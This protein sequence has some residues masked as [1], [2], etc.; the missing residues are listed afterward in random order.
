VS[1]IMFE[2]WEKSRAVIVGAGPVTETKASER[3]VIWKVVMA[4]FKE[5]PSSL[6]A[7]ALNA[8]SFERLFASVFTPPLLP[9]LASFS[10][11]VGASCALDNDEQED[12]YDT[13][14]SYQGDLCKHAHLIWGPPPAA[15]VAGGGGML[16][17]EMLQRVHDNSKSE[18]V[19]AMHASIANRHDQKHSLEVESGERPS[20]AFLLEVLK[21]PPITALLQ[22]L[23]QDLTLPVDQRTLN[24]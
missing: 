21:H 20:H 1:T 4:Y 17:E 24:V 13:L 10:N 15:V 14:A 23:Q 11:K 6:P 16:T 19:A 9:M 3:M 7:C 5:S 22:E 8:R 2:A 18:S 12:F